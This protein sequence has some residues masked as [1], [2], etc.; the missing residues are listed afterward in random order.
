MINVAIIN[1][2]ATVRDKPLKGITIWFKL[3]SL[4]IE[5]K[6]SQIRSSSSRHEKFGDDHFRAVYLFCETS[7]VHD[8]FL[9]GVSISQIFVH[10]IFENG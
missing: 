7:F 8:L 9:I 1:P 3:L 6:D 2:L 4:S 5:T 10:N